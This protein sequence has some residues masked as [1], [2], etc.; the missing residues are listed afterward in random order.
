MTSPSEHIERCRSCGALI[1]Y[2]LVRP[3]AWAPIEMH[4]DHTGAWH[5]CERHIANDLKR[6]RVAN[7][8]AA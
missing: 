4:G 3:G 7:A 5:S 1:E 2:V 6:K 8:D